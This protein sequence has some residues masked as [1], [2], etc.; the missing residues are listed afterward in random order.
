MEVKPPRLSMEFTTSEP[1]STEKPEYIT[2]R[3][4]FR[5]TPWHTMANRAP[6]AMPTIKVGMVGFFIKIS[7][8]TT[9][10]GMSSTGLNQKL[11]ET[12]ERMSSY[13]SP[14]TVPPA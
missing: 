10:T 6:T 12:V 1:E 4:S 8:T 7:T 14:P 3:M 5:P 9:A 13:T 11:A 2:V